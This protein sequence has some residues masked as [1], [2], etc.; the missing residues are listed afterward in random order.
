MPGSQCRKFGLLLMIGVM[1][2]A[3]PVYAQADGPELTPIYQI[4]K[5]VMFDRNV[6]Y[7]KTLVAGVLAPE[8]IEIGTVSI[9][10]HR[11]EAAL[12]GA[13]GAQF[14]V[15]E[16]EQH[17]NREQQ[18]AYLR[19]LAAE[20]DDSM[21]YYIIEHIYYDLQLSGWFKVHE[22]TLDD[23]K[24]R[25]FLLRATETGT[26]RVWLLHVLPKP[27][28]EGNVSYAKSEAL[29]LVRTGKRV[30]QW[31]VST[32]TV[33]IGQPAPKDSLAR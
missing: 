2:I 30:V 25:A 3:G 21:H 8:R 20:N 31:N 11:A 18:W 22:W 16:Q 6:D 4:P 24:I 5:L 10:V 27:V 28:P 9:S 19:A 32:N 26:W 1:G 29:A 23:L 33:V 7:K 15:I 14:A 17:R 12:T 13:L